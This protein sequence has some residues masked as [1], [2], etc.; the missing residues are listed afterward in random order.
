M[1]ARFVSAKLVV[2]EQ[3]CVLKSEMEADVL[4]DEAI[5]RIK[6][7]RRE[8]LECHELTRTWSIS[9]Y[10]SCLEQPGLV[11]TMYQSREKCY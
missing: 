10:V 2:G 5:G 6:T 11:N 8:V 3:A 4:G 9:G 7:T 1:S